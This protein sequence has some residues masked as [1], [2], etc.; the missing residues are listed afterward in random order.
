MIMNVESS[1]RKVLVNT[2]SKNLV[3]YEYTSAETME[4]LID[5]ILYC[6]KLDPAKYNV[7][8]QNS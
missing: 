7:L 3:E 2:L 5:Y 4:I 6:E 1:Y 8:V